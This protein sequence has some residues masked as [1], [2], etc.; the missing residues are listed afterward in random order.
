MS[1]VLV[2]SPQVR[3][4]IERGQGIRAKPIPVQKLVQ[5]QAGVV[6]IKRG[7]LAYWLYLNGEKGLLPLRKRVEPVRSKN[8]FLR[9]Q[10]ILKEKMQRLSKEWWIT[11]DGEGKQLRQLMQPYLKQLQRGTIALKVISLPIR[12]I[13]KVMPGKCDE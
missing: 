11:N 7:Q 10:V 6:A 12:M 5:S 3:D 13:R 4:I 8:L 9:Q 2:R 1:L